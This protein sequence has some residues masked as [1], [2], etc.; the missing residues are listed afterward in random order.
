MFEN[1]AES[2]RS[3]GMT[4]ALGLLIV[5][6][7]GHAAAGTALMVKS[8]WDIKKL[9]VPGSGVDLAIAPP[10]PPPPPLK[11]GKK[12]ETQKKPVVKKVKP[13]ESV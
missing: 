8:F 10:P 4:W 2:K 13:T 9:D 11:G 12:L 1:Y 3:K 6:V 5:V 7:A